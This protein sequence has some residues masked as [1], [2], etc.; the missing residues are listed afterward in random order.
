MV[1]FG[2]KIKAPQATA[3]GEAVVL[4]EDEKVPQG[5]LPE[6]SGGSSEP[7]VPVV[8]YTDTG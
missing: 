7:S 2:S 3:E 1:V 6:M 4:G 8:L 5:L